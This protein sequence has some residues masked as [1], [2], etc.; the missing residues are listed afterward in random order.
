ML[1]IIVDVHQYTA[2][3]MNVSRQDAKA[4]TFKPLYGGILGTPKEMRY[5]E[6]FKNKYWQVNNWHYT[7]QKEAVETKKINCLLAG[8]MHFQRHDGHDM[9]M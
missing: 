7:L 5:Y 6:A 9:V 2:D 1:K 4:H 8:N 3:T